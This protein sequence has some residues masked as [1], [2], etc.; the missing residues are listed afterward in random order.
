MSLIFSNL[1]LAP[2]QISG[3]IRIVP[4]IRDNYTGTLRL[5][6]QEYDEDLNITQVTKNISYISYVPHAFILSWSDDGVPLVSEGTQIYKKNSKVTGSKY[7]SMRSS[8]KMIKKIDKNKIHFL[9]LH[10]AMESF[11]NL[12]FKGPS[13]SWDEYSGKIK[14]TGLSPRIEYSYSGKYIDGLEEALRVF[15]I[16]ENQVGVLLFVADKLASV[17]IVPHPEDYRSLHQS[18]LK[19]FYGELIYY[20]GYMYP[21]VSKF[22]VKIDDDKVNSLSDLRNEL[23]QMKTDLTDFYKFMAEG[24]LQ[25][26]LIFNDV[27]NVGQHKLKRFMTDPDVNLENHIGEIIVDNDNNIE[28]LKTFHLSSEQVKKV[29]LLKNLDLHNWNLDE[30]ATYMNTTKSKLIMNIEKLGFGYLIKAH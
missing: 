11:L 16:H 18:L 1:K 5:Q 2:S 7:F 19:D 6:S 21:S 10:L 28:Y 27:Y 23:E 24:I 8:S 13:I 3:G 15:E 25:K 12:Y 22:Q 14:A 29:V 26:E 9:P 20:Y 4:V 30:T 17:F